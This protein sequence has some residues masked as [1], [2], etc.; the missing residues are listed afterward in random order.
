MAEYKQVKIGKL[1]LKGFSNKKKKNSKRKCQDGSESSV[2]SEIVP[3]DDAHLHGGWWPITSFDKLT[4]GNVAIQ[5]YT[6]AN[7]FAVDN[8]TLRLGSLHGGSDDGPVQEEIFTMIRLSDNKVGFK[9]GYGKYISVNARGD[10]L[11]RSDAVGPQEQLEVVIENGKVALQG[12]NGYFLTF[13]DDGEVKSLSRVAKEKEIIFLRTN[14]SRNKKKKLAEDDIG[15]VRKCEVSYV[16]QFQSFG[17]HKVKLHQ[18]PKSSLEK[19]RNVGKLHE[20]ML[21]RR[22]K[23]KSDRYCK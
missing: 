10:V 12:H 4:G 23:M 7:L 9:S 14:A 13:T 1:K 18:G 11:A 22:E 6:S 17:D 5:C 21:D 15:D 19:A 20:A 16:K 8:G 3:N 2:S